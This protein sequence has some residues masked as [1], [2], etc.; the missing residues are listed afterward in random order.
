MSLIKDRFDQRDYNVYV[1]CEQLHLKAAAG[2]DAYKDEFQTVTSFYGSDFDPRELEAH[3]ST[4]THN[5]PCLENV[6][7]S[8]VLVYLR[9][10]SS[11]QQQLLS[12]VIKLAKLILVMPATNATSERSFS[13]LRRVKTYSR[14]TKTQARLNHLMLL[15]VYKDKTSALC[16]VQIVNDCA[17]ESKYHLGIFGKLFSSDLVNVQATVKENSTQTKVSFLE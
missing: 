14:T 10:L 1:N 13:A 9:S 2:G 8:N 4:F 7:L 15:Y 11:H 6:T 16:M 17:R 5:I 12:Q 3:L